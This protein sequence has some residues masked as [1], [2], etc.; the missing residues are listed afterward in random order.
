MTDLPHFDESLDQFEPDGPQSEVIVPIPPTGPQALICENKC[1][2]ICG[3]LSLFTFIVAIVGYALPHKTYESARVNNIG[4]DF[5]EINNSLI[6]LHWVD[7]VSGTVFWSFACLALLINPSRK[8]HACIMLICFLTAVTFLTTRLV[9]LLGSLET[10]ESQ[11]LDPLISYEQYRARVLE[12]INSLPVHAISVESNSDSVKCFFLPREIPAI[13]AND[14]SS[15]AQLQPGQ[16]GFFS[17]TPQLS[18]TWDSASEAAIQESIRDLERSLAEYKSYGDLEW[19]VKREPHLQNVKQSEFVFVSETEKLSPSLASG[20][21]IAGAIFGL[22]ILHLYRVISL[23]TWQ[24]NIMK[25]DAVIGLGLPHNHTDI[26][27]PYCSPK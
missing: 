12:A 14:S 25:L 13:F 26:G 27:M 11:L 9:Y 2:I 22:G 21:K 7:T 6:A 4:A 23:P 8:I 15:F 20:A 3:V 16:P 5:L 10:A 17:A 18:V 19:S 1:A 24:D